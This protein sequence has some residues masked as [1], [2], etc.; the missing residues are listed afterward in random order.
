MT[1]R[2]LS[3][4]NAYS[5]ALDSY[6][7]KSDELKELAKLEP[8]NAFAKV[9]EELGTPLAGHLLAKGFNAIKAKGQ[10]LVEKGVDQARKVISDK[11]DEQVG[12]ISDSLKQATTGGESSADAAA[13]DAGVGE[14]EIA[15]TAFGK[16]AVTQI[17]QSVAGET[18]AVE[19][20]T[21]ASE[22]V[23]QTAAETGDIIG[24]QAGKA[25]TAATEAGEA[26][27]GGIEGGV[28]GGA[29][30]TAEALGPETG[31]IG[32]VVGGLIAI[33]TAIAG[34]FGHHNT[35]PPVVAIPNLSTPSFTSG[36]AQN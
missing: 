31:G 20:A 19:A 26:I 34:I 14:S 18:Q 16:Q 25:V 33:G 32:F 11:I 30:A 9:S 27:S 7:N 23:A 8:E 10:S 28:V 35:A 2:F 12:R 15:E 24:I 13:E 29:E 4:F 3:E 22:S 17:S 5:N 6:K 36:L 1:D 21:G